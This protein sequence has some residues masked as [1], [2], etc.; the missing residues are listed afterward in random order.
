MNYE[1]NRQYFNKIVCNKA[2]CKT[3]NDIIESK[4]KHDF[5]NCRCGSLAVDGGKDYIK[6]S[7]IPGQC[8]EL[9][10]SRNFTEEE[11]DIF[12]KDRDKYS[13]LSQ[14]LTESAKYFKNLWYPSS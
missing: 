11:F 12:I 8:I 13:Y 10:E 5:I 14:S 4:H 7:G 2:Q 3:C 6:R 9:S 1:Y